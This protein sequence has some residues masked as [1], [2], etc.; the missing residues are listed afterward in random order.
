MISIGRGHRLF[1]LAKF[2]QTLL[3]PLSHNSYLYT[4]LDK[5]FTYFQKL[6]W[7]KYHRM[8][9]IRNRV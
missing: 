5:M 4:T 9:N 8:S 3:V 1:Q 6:Y 2:I 7:T